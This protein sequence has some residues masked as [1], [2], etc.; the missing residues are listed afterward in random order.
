MT[1]M[2]LALDIED[3]KLVASVK[4]QGDLRYHS[5]GTENSRLTHAPVGVFQIERFDGLGCIDDEDLL[6]E[7]I[8]RLGSEE[9]VRRLGTQMDD[10]FLL[11]LV[12]RRMKRP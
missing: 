12:A 7:L 3:G 6:D 1:F 11:R 5:L 9:V 4:N 2:Y 8:K 10:D